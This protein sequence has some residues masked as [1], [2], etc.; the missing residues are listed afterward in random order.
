M[1]IIN[2]LVMLGCSVGVLALACG[3][4]VEPPP[5]DPTLQLLAVYPLSII[6]P[7]GLAID[8]SA[9]CLWTVTNNPEKV[10]QLDLSGNVIR[11][12]SYSGRDLEGIAYDSSDSTLWVAEEDRREIVHLDLTGAVLSRHRLDLTGEPNSGLEGICFDDQGRMFVLNEKLPGLLVALNP[13]YSIETSQ[14]LT[15][16]EDYSDVCFSR[17]SGCFWIVSDQSQRLYHFDRANG[18]RGRY[19]LPFHKGEG[20][21][22]D[23]AANRV[24]VVSDSENKLYVYAGP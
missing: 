3:S 15:F 22:F 24:Y 19:V 23:A 20:V 21:A 14:T 12:L 18:V 13:D 5:P 4:A 17:L 2:R 11:T 10:Y 6:E 1:R 9:T 8:D 16:A 7:S